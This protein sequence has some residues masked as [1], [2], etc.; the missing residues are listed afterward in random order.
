M[1]AIIQEEPEPLSRKAPSVPAPVRW[2]VE[3]LLSKEPGSRYHSTSDLASEL[4]TVRAHLS[5]AVSASNVVPGETPRLLRRVPFWTLAAVAALTAVL[6]LLFGGRHLRTRPPPAS[7]IVVSLSFPLDA[8]PNTDNS[9]PLALTRDG[10]TLVFFGGSGDRLFVRQL[11]RDE[12]RPIPGTEGAHQ[13]FISPDGLEVGF[14]AGGKLKK[15][16]LAGGSPVTLCDTTINRGGSWGEDGTIVF[17]PGSLSGLWRIPASGGEPRRVTTPDAA[18]GE[19]HYFPQLLPDGEHVLFDLIDRTQTSHAAVVS[20]R[21]GEQRILVKD[22]AYPRYL[23]TGH[24]VFARPGS[25]LGVRFDLNRLEISDS[26]VPLLD[27]LMTNFRGNRQ[28]EYTFSWQGTLAYVP[29]REFLRT[30][31]WVDRKGAAEQIPFPPRSYEQVALS[32]DGGRIAAMTMEKGERTALLFGDLVRGTLS[33]STAEGNV[34]S[35]VWTPDGKRVAFNFGP[36]GRGNGAVYCQSADGSTA[37]EPLTGEKDLEQ[38]SPDSFSPDGSVLLFDA[39]DP[40]DTTLANTSFDIFI[41]PL[42]GERK[43]RPFLGTKALEA[44]L[45]FRP[46][47]AGSRT[48]RASPGASRSTSGRSR[49]RAPDGRSRPKGDRIRAGP[50]AAGNFSIGKR[51]R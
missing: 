31:V 14:F 10:K 51:T 38:G 13:P 29:S 1:A 41:L 26:P 5:E 47:A 32:P 16:A 19:R 24:L 7:P 37:P 18:K 21:T 43:V 33:R 42:S 46:T 2:M 12:I 44:T 27:D 17:V 39:Y 25:L 34:G 11:D 45:V 22:A 3:R 9:S 15:V 35:P 8:S 48:S 40:A 36:G 23:P 30:L 49:A 4:A 50:G 20:L 28:A 6:G